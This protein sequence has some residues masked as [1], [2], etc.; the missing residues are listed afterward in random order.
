M[1]SS[2]TVALI[3]AGSAGLGAA[4]ARAFA[5]SGYRVAVNYA[6]NDA[7][8]LA[9]VAELPALSPLPLGD[10]GGEG[11]GK[12]FVA[13]KADLGSRDEIG[14]LVRD[15]VARF[16]RL[17]VVFSNGGW[18]QFRG[19]SSIDKNAYED[20]WDKSFNINVKSHLWLMQVAKPHLDATEGAF[21]STASVAGVKPGGS[22]LAYSVTKAAQL[23]LMRALAGM[24]APKV[25]VNSVSP[26]LL[27]T[28]W[29]DMFPDELKEATRQRSKLQRLATVED[30]AEQ[31]LT[32]ARS[33]S[34]TG[35]N[36]VIDGGIML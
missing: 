13:I 30:V 24:A 34:T 22:S 23:H 3:T 28:D 18:T 32:L 35:I 33:R 14:R 11:G 1:S 31:V 21:I 26:G 25:R 29:A 36:V 12:N 16:G 8:A 6:N 7:R 27:L 17:D 2:A 5:K 15:A 4:A 20:E 9:L 19:L 10:E